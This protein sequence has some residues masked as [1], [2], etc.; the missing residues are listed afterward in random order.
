MKHK[1]NMWLLTTGITTIGVM[2][3]NEVITTEAGMLLYA[4][5]VSS[6][7]MA[8]SE[9]Y[10]HVARLSKWAMGLG[11][12]SWGIMANQEAIMSS[13]SGIPV[14]VLAI[15]GV[16][17]MLLMTIVIAY[18]VTNKGEANTMEPK[19]S[20]DNGDTY[21]EGGIGIKLL[22]WLIIIIGIVGVLMVPALGILLII[23]LL[24]VLISK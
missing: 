3:L 9:D 10:K 16:M 21:S 14:P 11:I 24:I 13:G 4:I 17:A 1:A 18:L 5:P 6:M 15:G 19:Y 8:L 7:V 2:G 22:A 20:Y 12:V 23:V